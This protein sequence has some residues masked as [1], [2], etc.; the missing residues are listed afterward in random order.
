MIITVELDTGRLHSPATYE[1]KCIIEVNHER[2]A[3]LDLFYATPDAHGE[4]MDDPD[5]SAPR[6]PHI[7][8]GHWP[9]GEQ[10]ERL[11]V[12]PVPDQEST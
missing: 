9:D 11:A 8:I 6:E 1:S 12:I 5:P 3:A 10:W 7:V 4:Y 2:V